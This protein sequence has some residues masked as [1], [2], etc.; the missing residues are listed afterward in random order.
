MTPPTHPRIPTPHSRAR[1][2]EYTAALEQAKLALRL[3]EAAHGGGAAVAVAAHLVQVGEAMDRTGVGTD[4]QKIG[5]F[6]KAK[7]IWDG[8][9]GEGQHVA[10]AR[11]L[12]GIG[13]R[14]T[15]PGQRIT[16][17]PKA[18]EYGREALA[19]VQRSGKGGG[20]EEARPLEL[21][22]EAHWRLEQWDEA[23]AHY[24]RQL[25]LL[26]D[27]HGEEGAKRVAEVAKAY[28]GIGDVYDDGKGDYERALE[29][30]M[31]AVPVAEEA[32]GKLSDTTGRLC[33]S[34]AIAY[35]RQQRWAESV[36]WRERAV[37]AFT[38]TYGAEHE[39][40]TKDAQKWLE[41]ARRE[42]AKQ[43]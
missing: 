34:I 2:Q 24:Q 33:Q 27:H 41:E 25:R 14:Y 38:F 8:E 20:I 23:L 37:A 7:R 15:N 26:L 35:K 39:Q 4:E 16:D 18:L 12:V 3:R 28:Q 11:C 13:L 43:K 29:Q 30:Y 31:K 42:A 40:Y 21:I 1:P 19:V 9:Y 36:P 10:T 32:T 17:H 6:E 22:G 5:L